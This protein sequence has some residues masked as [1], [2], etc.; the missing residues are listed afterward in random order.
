MSTV[1]YSQEGGSYELS[2]LRTP[3]IEADE[4]QPRLPSYKTTSTR[5]GRYTKSCD[6][7]AATAAAQSG[8]WIPHG[9]SET[10]S[11]WKN[12]ASVER[13]RGIQRRLAVPCRR[14][15]APAALAGARAGQCRATRRRLEPHRERHYHSHH[16]HLLLLFLLAC[17]HLAASVV[18]AASIRSIA[19]QRASPLVSGA[20]RSD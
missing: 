11:R 20:A 4:R 5:R 1:K 16:H 9:N 12:S 17:S 13:V 14:P 7:Q 2:S 8:I 19:A 6:L 3:V 15:H 18:A 10:P